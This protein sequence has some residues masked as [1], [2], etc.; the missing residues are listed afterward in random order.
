MAESFELDGVEFVAFTWGDAPS[1]EGLTKAQAD[2][3]AL[4][5]RGV[6]NAEIARVRGTSVRTVANQVAAILRRL[7]VASRFE[8]IARFGGLARDA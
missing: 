7:S 8:L 5:V 3:F 4:L 6:S 2:V 1:L